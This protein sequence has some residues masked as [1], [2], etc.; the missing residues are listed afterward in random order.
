MIK[1]NTRILHKQIEDELNDLINSNKKFNKK[2][3]TF[4]QI[5]QTENKKQNSNQIVPVDAYENF[6][7]FSDEICRNIEKF[8][9]LNDNSL[10]QNNKMVMNKNNNDSCQNNVETNDLEEETTSES[11]FKT[12][13]IKECETNEEKEKEDRINKLLDQEIKVDSNTSLQNNQCNQFKNQNASFNSFN[14][15]PMQNNK[16]FIKRNID[17]AEISQNHLRFV[18][19]SSINYSLHNESSD[20]LH[21]ESFLSIDNIRSKLWL[22]LSRTKRNGSCLDV[23]VSNNDDDQ[24]PSNNQPNSVNQII[25]K[26][27]CQQLDNQML[28]MLYR[29]NE[30]DEHLEKFQ[31]QRKIDNENLNAILFVICYTKLWRNSSN[32]IEQLNIDLNEITPNNILNEPIRPRECALSTYQESRELKER[33]NEIE[34]RLAEIQKISFEEVSYGKYAVI[35]SLFFLHFNS[36]ITMSVLQ[37]LLVKMSKY[38]IMR[39]PTIGLNGPPVLPGFP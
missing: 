16:N 28:G 35:L 38:V 30:I 6:T 32:N 14:G 37:K 20:T 1:E 7:T 9:Q 10:S 39:S 17:L 21:N 15:K 27:N 4:K 34:T 36:F 25:L 19:R 11:I 24:N 31:I 18:Q 2:F 13:Y 26:G 3:K 22:C 23:P 5:N 8:L 33:L 12:E 29:L